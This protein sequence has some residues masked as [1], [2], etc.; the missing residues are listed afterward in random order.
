MNETRSNT[1]EIITIKKEIINNVDAQFILYPA[2][3]KCIIIMQ[4]QRAKIV[5]VQFLVLHSQV[6]I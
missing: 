6:H 4:Y 3:Q 2:I 5:L 1:K